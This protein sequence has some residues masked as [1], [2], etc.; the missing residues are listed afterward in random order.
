[1]RYWVHFFGGEFETADSV[2][3]ELT[4]DPSATAR[5]Q[6]E[7]YRLLAATDLFH[8][9]VR[10][11]LDHLDDSRRAASESGPTAE[12][13]QVMTQ[14]GTYIYLGID[15]A[16][17]MQM[18][19][20][21]QELLERVPTVARPYLILSAW[22]SVANRPARA[23]AL[24]ETWEASVPPGY[25]TDDDRATRLI[26][27]GLLAWR[28]GDPAAGLD[29]VDQ[30]RQDLGCVDCWQYERALILQDLGTPDEV[31]AAWEER[32]RAVDLFFYVNAGEWP[33]AYERLCQLHA[34][35]GET[36]AA[37][38]HCSRFVELWAEADPE[39]QPRVRAA[40]QRLDAVTEG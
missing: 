1:M 26:A 9:R 37:A 21:A 29:L 15:P 34:E 19:V 38:R 3:Q 13:F 8:G 16:R 20:D 25:Q 22:A 27:E 12:F 33:I 4:R 18:I 5:W 36:T 32:A 40:Q 14:A 28:R 39:L 23:E 7:A 6:T 11:A 2:A 31:I 24:I 35:H 17:G 10:D 30:G